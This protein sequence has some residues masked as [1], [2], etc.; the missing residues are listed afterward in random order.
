MAVDLINC[1]PISPNN[2]VVE[3][4]REYLFYFLDVGRHYKSMEA[5]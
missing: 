1:F 5:T 4:G 2:A 3:K